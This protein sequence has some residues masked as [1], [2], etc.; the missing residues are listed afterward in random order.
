M[1]A[2]WKGS[3]ATRPVR[4]ANDEASDS[5]TAPHSAEVVAALLGNPTAV[6]H[7]EGQSV[8]SAPGLYAWWAS[9]GLVP[10][11]LHRADGGRHPASAA[12]LELIYVGIA[13]DLHK[14]LLG[15]HLGSSTGG[16]TLRQTLASLLASQLGL[17]AR[18]S[19][20]GDRVTLDAPSEAQLMSWMRD[21]MHVTWIPYPAPSAAERSVIQLLG[22]P[23][24][25]DYNEQHPNFRRMV[26]ARAAWRASAG[27]P[28]RVSPRGG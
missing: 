20:N 27:P 23:C 26:E 5:F 18:W 15:K 10:G 17:V 1:A 13:S 24:N 16:S 8:P 22:P 25:V 12:A 4:R 21:S 28:H 6:R 19:P 9:P 2:E 11:I 3:G 14:R 7:L